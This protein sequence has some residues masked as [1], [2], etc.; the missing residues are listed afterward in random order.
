M[1]MR[2]TEIGTMVT[3]KLWAF[4]EPIQVK[5][6]TKR[7]IEDVII[8]KIFEERVDKQLHFIN[9]DNECEQ[10]IPYDK[11]FS[12]DKDKEVLIIDGME[13]LVIPKSG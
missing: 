8:S 12:I 4:D 2:A 1:I 3:L 10:I 13:I 6:N 7:G 5:M 9:T 11:S